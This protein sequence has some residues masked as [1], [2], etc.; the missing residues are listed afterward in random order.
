MK[1]LIAIDDNLDTERVLGYLTAHDAWRSARNAYTL[2]TV[3]HPTSQAMS[4]LEAQAIL[5]PARDFCAAHGLSF[6]C[7][8]RSG[9]PASAIVE[10]A[11]REAFDLIVMGAHRRS[12]KDSPASKP[13]SYDVLGRTDIPVLLVPHAQL[14]ETRRFASE[15]MS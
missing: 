10:F 12:T 8:H 9:D 13:V 7:S 14:C 4:R 1:I 15:E 11:A 2:L 3:T 5:K 6:A